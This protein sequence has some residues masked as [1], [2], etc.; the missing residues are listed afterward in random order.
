MKT[1]ANRVPLSGKT[2]SMPVCLDFGLVPG[3]HLPY[4]NTV[5]HLISNQ[6][7]QMGALNSSCPDLPRSMAALLNSYGAIWSISNDWQTWI[8]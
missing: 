8:P 3:T 2:S 4:I 5:Q 1:S 6:D 7:K